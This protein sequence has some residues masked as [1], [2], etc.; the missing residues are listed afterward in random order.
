MDRTFEDRLRDK[1]RC[2]HVTCDQVISF[3]LVEE[4]KSPDRRLVHMRRIRLI[5]QLKIRYLLSLTSDPTDDLDLIW[6]D[7]NWSEFGSSHGK[8]DVWPR[9]ELSLTFSYLLINFRYLNNN[10]IKTLPRMSLK[11]LPELM[12]L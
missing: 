12:K 8:F 4:K 10:S 1:R 7:P 6:V 5:N 3:F 2:S 11:N 9:P